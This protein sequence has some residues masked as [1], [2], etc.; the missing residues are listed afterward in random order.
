MSAMVTSHL[1]L[2]E[3]LAGWL[4]SPLARRPAATWASDPLLRNFPDPASA[5]QAA[6]TDDEVFRQ[7]ADR[8][9]DHLATTVCLSVLA[10]QLL[11]IAQG[12]AIC[13]LDQH[14]LADAEASLVAE[15][16]A[17]IRS[18]P[19]L[20]PDRVVQRAWHRVSNQRRTARARSARTL[21][22]PNVSDHP[23]CDEEAPTDVLRV[24]L[25]LISRWITDHTLT[26]SA[27]AC[28]WAAICGWSSVQAASLAGCPL[29]AWRS[30]HARA[31]RAARASLLAEGG[32]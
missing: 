25:S 24:G 28:L 7:L 30:R 18:D 19:D 16:L 22:L 13:G 3:S 4:D 6:T 32:L 31:R 1:T 14:D 8:R 29:E 23:D 12:W 20:S 5:G 21:P 11:P 2:L 10:G 26:V 15:A 17:A 27:A 9:D